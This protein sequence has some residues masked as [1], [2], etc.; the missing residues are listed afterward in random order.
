MQIWVFPQPTLFG[1]LQ[2]GVVLRYSF[3]GL[4]P[5]LHGVLNGSPSVLQ[6]NFR[7]YIASKWLQNAMMYVKPTFV[8]QESVS[9]QRDALEREQKVAVEGQCAGFSHPWTMSVPLLVSATGDTCDATTFF[10]GCK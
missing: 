10:R 7:V 4:M 9:P 5:Q 2:Q 6:F 1:I 8:S 3:S